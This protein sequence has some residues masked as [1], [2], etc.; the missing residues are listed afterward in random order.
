[1]EKYITDNA[2]GSKTIDFSDRPVRI[3]GTEVKQLTMREPT[4]DDEMTGQQMG[5]GNDREAECIIF[6][7]L[8]GL[9][10]DNI[11]GLKLREYKR[12]QVAYVGF[13]D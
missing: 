2:D 13:L 11:K 5:K 7:N 3:D 1:M 12:L 4:V 6:A 9:A 10:P 8:T